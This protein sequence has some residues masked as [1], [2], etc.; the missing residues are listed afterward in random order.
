MATAVN[1]V[2]NADCDCFDSKAILKIG[3]ILQADSYAVFRAAYRSQFASNNVKC[4]YVGKIVNLNL[5]RSAKVANTFQCRIT[6]FI[7]EAMFDGLAIRITAIDTLVGVGAVAVVLNIAGIAVAL[8][9]NCKIV[10][11][12]L[13]IGGVI[14]CLG[15]EILTAGF[16]LLIGVVAR[17][18]AGS[19]LGCDSLTKC[20]AQGS[21]LAV[22]I[23]VTALRAGMGGITLLGA[24]GRSYISG[25]FM[26]RGCKGHT[27][28]DTRGLLFARRTRRSGVVRF[29]ALDIHC[30]DP[31]A[32]FVDIGI[33][34]AGGS[35]K[36][37][38]IG[39]FQPNRVNRDFIIFRLRLLQLIRNSLRSGSVKFNYASFN[40]DNISTAQGG[41]YVT[42]GGI[43]R[44]FYNDFG[45]NQI[46]FCSGIC[47]AGGVRQCLESSCSA[48]GIINTTKC[49]F[50]PLFGVIDI[51]TNIVVKNT[52]CIRFNCDY[53]TR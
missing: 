49:K 18:L 37:C 17:R 52:F 44:T 15:R 36:I 10:C 34:A 19:I 8:L 35:F 1:N 41:I 48:I 7:L 21:S 11:I 50:A 20:M 42:L 12:L 5:N 28:D 45:I 22:S 33:C 4:A 46:S 38:T 3:A 32:V 24:G 29:A 25:I 43:H 14:A 47:S 31:L 9:R 53:G 23:A 51:C 6:F 16:T 27:A 40:A 30:A 39:V 2:S 13:A 26:L